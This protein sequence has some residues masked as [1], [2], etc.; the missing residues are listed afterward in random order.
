MNISQIFTNYGF[1]ELGSRHVMALCPNLSKPSLSRS[2][3]NNFKTLETFYSKET[4]RCIVSQKPK[5]LES[6]LESWIEFFMHYGVPNKYIKKMLEHHP[7][8]FI[9]STIFELG[10]QI[11]EMKKSGITDFEIQHL[12]I[13]YHPHLFIN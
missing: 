5:L 3:A 8:I 1:S 4:I 6:N 11:L 2:V 9:K 7:D 10:R 13:P 12:Y